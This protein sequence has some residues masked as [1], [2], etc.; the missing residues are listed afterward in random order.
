MSIAAKCHVDNLRIECL[1]LL[2]MVRFTATIQ[3]FDQHGEKTGWTYI[4]IPEDIAEK[5][6][7][8][9]RKTFRVKGKLDEHVI[10]AVALMPMKGGGFIMPVNGA[11][12]KATGKRRG[13][14]LKVQ[15]EEDTARLEPPAELLECLADEPKAKAYFETLTYGHKNYFTKWIESAKTEPTRTK[16]IAQAVDALS[17]QM[18]FGTMLRSLKGKI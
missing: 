4:E 2:Y 16:R 17:R 1:T 18:D 12:R 3:Q 9:N 7:P 5:I 13:A 11:M 8:G 10:N 15:M 14:V 6:K